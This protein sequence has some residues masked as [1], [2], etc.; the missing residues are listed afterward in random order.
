MTQFIGMITFLVV[1]LFVLSVY[2]L[3][4]DKQ[5][6]KRRKLVKKLIDDGGPKQ[7]EESRL[8]EEKA[9][10]ALENVAARFVDLAVLES[11]LLSAE[12]PLSL[13]RFLTLSLALGVLLLLPALALCRHPFFMLL[14]G[15][16]GIILPFAYLVYR[17][18]RR[19]QAL[20]QQLPDALD[21]I[22]RA[23]RVG[24][25]VDGA[26]QEV[27]RSVPP[28]FGA[29]MRTV[30]EEMAMGLPF[31][32]ALRNF[33]RRFPS[34]PDVKIFCTAFV[35]QRDTGGN[36]TRILEALAKTIRER[37][38]L[39]RQVK[40]L[41]AEGRTTSIIL[42]ILPLVFVGITWLLNPGYIGLLF[43]HP[44]GKKLLLLALILEAAGFV[45]MR[46][47]SRIDA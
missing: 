34:V 39:N 8:R 19:E 16:A 7:R 37:F 45:V 22:V 13:E 21:M 30:Y 2:Y 9:R 33:E 29:E 20:V 1:T 35:I 6:L 43:A 24:Q 14:F 44:L 40:A 3:V 10:T 46:L 17:R 25:S 32:T 15:G 18:R 38:S 11:L 41:T 27:A 31:D 36:L 42:G 5:E 23:L 28:P 26:L 12:I 47:M 4:K